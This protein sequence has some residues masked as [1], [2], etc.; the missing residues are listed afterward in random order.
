MNVTTVEDILAT[1]ESLGSE[2]VRKHS[3]KNGAGDNQFGVKMGDIRKVAAGIKNNHE[4]GL[5]LWQTQNI[6]AQLVA[7][8][9]IKP[10]MLSTQVL[11][12]MV[13]AI[14]YSQVA[15]WLN[16]YVV[17]K[18]PEKETLRLAWLQS[19]DLW[20][21]RSGWSLTSERIGKDPEELDLAALLDRIDQEMPTAPKE[22]QWTMN[23][24]LAGIGINFAE[25]RDRAMQIGE[26]LGVF[27]D[28]PTSKGCTSPFAPIWITEMVKRQG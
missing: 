20:L 7:I 13:R 1:L 27:R 17:K 4:L 18:H 19:D 2:S 10:K 23:F 6:D 16:A 12:D 25:Y 11:E 24:C 15:D 9:V 8:L 5:A 14:P 26:S 22:V 3:R 28:F 21:A